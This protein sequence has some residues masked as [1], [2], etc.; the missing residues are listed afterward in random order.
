MTSFEFLIKGVIVGFSIAAP[1]GPI[2]LLCIRRS[3]A[4]GALTGLATGLG[5]ATADALYGAFAGFG[6]RAVTDALMG[7]Q[8]AFR[9]V[10]GIVLLWLA[11]V[12]IRTPPAERAAEAAPTR[13]LAGA[14]GSTF[15]LTLTNPATIISFAAVFSGLGMAEGDHYTAIALI[16]GVFAGSA[17]WWLGLS[18]GVGLFRK[19]LPPVFL[20]WLNRVS[21]AVLGAFG[22]AALVSSILIA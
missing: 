8:S 10:G 11:W 6:V 5:A 13:G 9:L 14:Y 15:A 19:R 18:S 21:G 1:V 20:I 7:W 4:N 2:G 12:T 17:L 16:G 3:L 22:V